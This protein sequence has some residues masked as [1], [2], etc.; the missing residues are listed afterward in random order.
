[1]KRKEEKKQMVCKIL[2][3][4]YTNISFTSGKK[5]LEA[6]HNNYRHIVISQVCT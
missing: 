4:V 3:I 5:K 2:I 6:V 1:V